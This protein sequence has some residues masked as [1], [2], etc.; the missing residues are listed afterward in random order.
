MK[1]LPVE[2][3]R[4]ADS[5]TIEHE[6][7]ANIDLMERAAAA[8]SNWLIKNISKDR[9][10]HIFCGTGN[11]GGDGFAIAR[12]LAFSGFTVSSYLIGDPEGMSSGCRIN[13]ARLKA[14]SPLILSGAAQFPDLSENDIVID[15][16]F[17]NGLTRPVTGLAARVIS[18]I[19][20][21]GA[22]VVAIDVPS[23]LFCDQ[24]TVALDHQAVVHADYTLTFSPPKQALFFPENDL[25][26]GRW[27][28]IEIGLSKEFID[29]Q[30]IKNFTV[31]EPDCMKILKKRNKFAH[32]GNF[33]HALLICGSTGKS[34][35]AVLAAK[36]CLRA[37]PGLVTIHIPGSALS[38]LQ[39]AVPEAMVSLDPDQNH[40][41]GVPELSM[42]SAVA[43]GP[44]MGTDQ[45][46]ASA[47]KLL[48][49][50]AT[51]PLI[52]DADAINILAENKT[53]LGFLPK[54]CI[55]TPHPREFERLAGKSSNHFDRNQLQRNFSFRH[56][57]YVVLKGAHTAITDPEGRCFFNT[58]GNPGMA[59][60]GSGD[61]LTGILAGLLAQG[62]SP[63][64]TCILG[65][66]IHGRAGDFAL[67]TQGFESLI[68][69][70]II[71]HM[72]KA[73]QSLYGKL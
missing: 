29:R 60:G 48:I 43:T 13:F 54:G 68:A 72:S 7:I 3:I 53:W 10:L 4:E 73:F 17:G 15:A 50:N 49:Q 23:G 55:F 34:G 5:Y 18:H 27:E 59:T 44:G 16:L 58:T 65:V 21:S 62:Y 47:I 35:A 42:Y 26:L 31:E 38:V 66:F 20:S 61:V 25:F 2:K 11:N 52:L 24:S 51:G 22:L 63:L 69:G 45:Q 8:C 1:V 46:T 67:A 12:I 6:P 28:L 64:E 70:D 30:E 19:N 39:T 9:Q 40:F 71:N 41:S 14:P 37:G 56:H 33:G 36:A 57:C 32:K